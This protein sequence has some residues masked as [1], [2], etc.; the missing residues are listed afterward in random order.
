[1]SADAIRVSEIVRRSAEAHPDRI[2]VQDLAGTHRV[3]Y[4]ELCEAASRGAAALERCGLEPGDRVLLSADA[5]PDW[6]A[7]LLAIADADL[8][9]VPIP[10]TTP[11]GLAYMAARFTGVR[12][13]IGTEHVAEAVDRP[14][15]VARLTTSGLLHTARPLR[16]P[17]PVRPGA[18]AVLV[19]TSGS[20][21][22]PRAVALS[23]ENLRANLRSL[24]AVRQARPGEAVLSTLPP[25][26]AY[27][28]VGGILA[29]LASGARVVFG[30]PPLP[31]RLVDGL[32][33]QSI[34]RAVLVP[35]LFEALAREVMDGLARD[36]VIDRSSVSSSPRALAASVR[37]MSAARLQGL[38]DAVRARL[39][40][41]LRTVV[42]G[43][44][45]L[46]PEWGS[47]LSAVGIDLDLGYGLT[48]AGPIVAVGLASECPPGSVGR[49]LPGVDVRVAPDG[50]ILVR[51]AS[52]M[53]GYAAD[54]QATAEAFDGTWL[55]TGDRG[56]LDADG[57]IFITGRIKE[58]M[59]T[60]DG[61]T[62]YPDEIEPWY[63]APDFAEVAVVPGTARDGNDRPVLVLVPAGPSIDRE[64]IRRTVASLRAAA[65]PRLRVAGSVCR[66]EPL[67]RTAAGKIRRRALAAEIR[68]T[69]EL[70]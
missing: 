34:T 8:V 52:V 35:S 36:G 30:G 50:E 39:G 41:A 13:W 2:A 42:V 44:A 53:Q 38:R 4:G 62:I 51:S 60:A 49:A 20:T 16:P 54:A 61:E 59:V 17:R 28:L 10:A 22:R 24:L 65:P 1:M 12:A 23:H 5:G 63:R 40:P 32:R 15:D 11:P 56:C 19:F 27:E 25:S 47:L 14:I 55:R 58:A 31:N 64:S 46:R 48:E 3:T 69:E 33:A 6:V 43:G 67:P 29:P 21:A 66:A 9:A 26:H 68:D 57:F 45:A 18:T 37:S 70:S 7:A